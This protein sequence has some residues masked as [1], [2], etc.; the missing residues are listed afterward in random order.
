MKRLIVLAALFAGGAHASDGQSWCPNE[1]ETYYLFSDALLIKRMN[2][3]AECVKTGKDAFECSMAWM[4][5]KS[6]DKFKMT[7]TPRPDGKLVVSVDG[8]NPF[9]VDRCE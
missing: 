8:G 6:P 9:E 1:T 3:K 7:A 5:G 4:D 2:A